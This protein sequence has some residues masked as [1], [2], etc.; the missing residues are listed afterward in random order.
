MNTRE[1]WLKVKYFDFNKFP[2]GFSRSGD[3][4]LA[5]SKILEDYGHLIKALLNNE[6]SD[7]TPEDIEIRNLIMSG[8]GENNEVARAWL[9]YLNVRHSKIS[10]SSSVSDKEREEAETVVDWASDDAFE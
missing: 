3:L 4:N 9:K 8:D 7:P 2:Y 5:Q 1:S 6:V 10:V